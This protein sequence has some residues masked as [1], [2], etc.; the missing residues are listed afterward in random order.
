MHG[1]FQTLVLGLQR[2]WIAAAALNTMVIVLPSSNTTNSALNAVKNLLL[3]P[4]IVKQIAH[5]AKVRSH[6]LVALNTLLC[7]R[8]LSLAQVAAHL[9]N[10]EAV[11]LMLLAELRVVA[12]A[13]A[14]PLLAALG[15]HVAAPSV[16]R[17]LVLHLHWRMASSSQVE[18]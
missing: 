10:G 15:Q 13:T 8:L 7:A 18:L 4:F 12:Q 1:A 14:H 17:A 5:R 2:V 3:Q 6:V 11:D 16:V 9:L